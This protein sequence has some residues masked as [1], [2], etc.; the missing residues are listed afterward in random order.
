MDRRKFI[1]L[2]GIGI[3]SFTLSGLVIQKGLEFMKRIMKNLIPMIYFTIK[4]QF[5]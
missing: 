5:K 4:L 2:G 3:T 1:N